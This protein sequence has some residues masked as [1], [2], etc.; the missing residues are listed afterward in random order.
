M[1]TIFIPL[2]KLI[3]SSCQASTIKHN[4]TTQITEANSEVIAPVPS[5]SL[6][7]DAIISGHMMNT[8][9]KATLN[10]DTKIKLRI[11]VLLIPS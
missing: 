2:N 8:A 7:I 10:T 1:E 9:D 5:S 4:A 3:A 6:K 11:E